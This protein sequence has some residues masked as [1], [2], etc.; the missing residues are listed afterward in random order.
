VV[1]QSVKSNLREA[2]A[3]IWKNLKDRKPLDFYSGETL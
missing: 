1:D 2:P 3:N